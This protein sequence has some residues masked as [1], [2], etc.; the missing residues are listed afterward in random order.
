MFITGHRE[1]LNTVLAQLPPGTFSPAQV[2]RMHRGLEYVD[3]PCGKYVVQDG[4]VVLT[5]QRLCRLG[6]LLSLFDSRRY[7]ESS[8]FQFH[9]GFFAH[10]HAM[11]TDPE[12]TVLKIRDKI[13]TTVLGLSLLALFDTRVFDAP[14]EEGGTQRSAGSLRPNAFWVGMV[15]HTITDSYSPAHTIR[16]TTSRVRRVRAANKSDDDD[17]DEGE[18]MRIAVHEAIKALARRST[19]RPFDSRGRFTDALERSM[20]R[21]AAAVAFARAQS[22][23]LYAIYKVYRHQYDLDAV[24]GAWAPRRLWPRPGDRGRY[25][26]VVSFQHYGAQSFWL[27]NRLD[28]LY[29]VKRDARMFERMLSDCRAYLLM[30]HEALRTGDVSAF[31]RGVLRLMLRGTFQVNPRYFDQRTD[32]VV[33][34]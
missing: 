29:Y 12:N 2:K 17:D 1:I 27:H 3:T 13:V 4:H 15:L 25:G 9:K 8:V 34:A 18:R 11:T 23:Q 24:V 14:P 7:G 22:S 6:V 10:L 32:R 28:L 19:A 33:V 21:D 16:K 5:K 26:D 30:Y 20:E 31:L